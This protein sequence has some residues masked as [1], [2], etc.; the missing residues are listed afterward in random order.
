MLG[1]LPTQIIYIA[2]PPI[3]IAPQSG[4]SATMPPELDVVDAVDAVLDA[5]DAVKNA[6]TVDS[7]DKALSIVLISARALL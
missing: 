5:V 1:Q 7:A 6:I 2:A 4:A 3:T